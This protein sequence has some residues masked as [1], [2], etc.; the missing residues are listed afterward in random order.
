MPGFLPQYFSISC[1]LGLSRLGL[2]SRA[3]V[4]GALGTAVGAHPA[5]PIRLSE[6]TPENSLGWKA[7]AN[8]DFE[9]LL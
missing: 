3:M 9:L 2:I 6:E 5:G 1:G 8:R 4:Y 7:G